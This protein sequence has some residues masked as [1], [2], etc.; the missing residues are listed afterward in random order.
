MITV[1][2]EG[3]NTVSRNITR[4]KT[5][6]YKGVRT[7]IVEGIEEIQKGANSYLESHSNSARWWGAPG[8]GTI[9]RERLDEKIRDNWITQPEGGVT[10]SGDFLYKTL[11]NVSPHAHMVEFGTTGPITS[12]Q[13]GKLYFWNGSK[14]IST[15]SV[16]GQPGK[17]YLQTSVELTKD[18][19]IQNMGE[20][21]HMNWRG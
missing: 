5:G 4:K 12:V 14:W 15:W 6:A 3:F 10:H 21:I 1:K 7:G 17:H 2:L 18:W 9:T 19:I 8:A 20:L 11:A 16:R 13:G